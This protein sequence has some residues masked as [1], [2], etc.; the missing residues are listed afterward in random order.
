MAIGPASRCLR[1]WCL[2][3]LR[4]VRG[5]RVKDDVCVSW[6]STLRKMGEHSVCGRTLVESSEYTY[7]VQSSWLDI[8][9]VGSVVRTPGIYS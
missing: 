6:F 3:G 5:S 8:R 2:S 4:S 9:S 7:R 1:R